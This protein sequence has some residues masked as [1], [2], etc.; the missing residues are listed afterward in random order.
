MQITGQILPAG[1][2]SKFSRQAW[3]DLIVRRPEFRRRVPN[4]IRNPFA[5]SRIAS[6]PT[7]DDAAEVLIDDHVIGRA[8]WSMSDEVLVNVVVE[9]NA[10]PLVLEWARELGGTFREGY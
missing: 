8:Y 7:T 6:V 10:V 9:S 2:G 3:C 4:Q 5:P 1:D